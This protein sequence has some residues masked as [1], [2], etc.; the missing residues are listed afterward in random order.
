MTART[1]DDLVR[2][3]VRL[4][5]RPYPAYQDLKGAYAFPAFTLI[6]DHVQGDPFAAPSRF[7]VRVPLAAAGFPDACWSTPSRTAGV[8]SHLARGFADEA[9]RQSEPVGSGKGA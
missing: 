4:D 2:A 8:C 9:R 1:R 3:A 7:R 5:G 6:L